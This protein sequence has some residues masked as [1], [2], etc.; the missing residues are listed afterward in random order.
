MQRWDAGVNS[1][2]ALF[3]LLGDLSFSRI[4]EDTLALSVAGK[5]ALSLKRPSLDQYRTQLQDVLDWAPLR[6]DRASEILAQ[7]TDMGAFFQSVLPLS[8]EKNASTLLLL[9]IATQ[10]SSYI[11]LRFK[12]EFGCP[13]P[14]ELSPQIQPMIPTPMHGAY[15]M[16]HMSEAVIVANLL[17]KLTHQTGSPAWN[18]M[19]E[20]LKRIAIRIGQNR[21]VAGV[22][23]PIDLAGG[24]AIGQWISDYLWACCNQGEDPVSMTAKQFDAQTFS[25]EPIPGM[26]WGSI[27]SDVKGKNEDKPIQVNVKSRIFVQALMP[28]AAAEWDW[29]DLANTEAVLK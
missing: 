3:D 6:A 4:D 14:V 20:Q 24:L 17:S 7:T 27:L 19:T 18:E 12:H 11:V 21:I 9:K 8:A 28:M 25:N 22:H 26:N 2:L 16:G 13:R 29:L 23:Y 15:P 10:L 1:Q 5:P